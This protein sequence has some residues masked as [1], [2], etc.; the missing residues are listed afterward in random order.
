MA[1][2]VDLTDIIDNPFQPRTSFDEDALRSLAAE[3]KA[4]GY[5]NGSLQGRRRKN[6]KVELVF[7]HRRLR[8]LRLLKV[9]SVKIDLVDLTDAQMALRSLEENLQR[10]GLTDLEK[11]DAVKHTVDQVRAEFRAAGKSEAHAIADVAE[12]LGL[13]VQ[14]VTQLCRISEGMPSKI[15]PLIEAKHLTAQTA[16]AAKEWGGQVY[17]ETLAKQG[18]QAVKDGTIAKPTHMTVKAMR[19]VVNQAPEAVREKLKTLIVEGKIT[20]P[21]EAERR[22]RSLTSSDVKRRRE[23]PPDLRAVIV[24]WTDRIK[25]WEKQMREVQPYMEYV[26]EVPKIAEQFRNALGQFIETARTLL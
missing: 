13:S 5:W 12:R 26:E 9:P 23:P 4:E 2:Q 25:D 21:N 7:G 11:S 14:W 17:V 20:T 16:Y 22:T 18:K 24:G 19:K 6:G 3:I 15:R 1:T 8:A 10:E